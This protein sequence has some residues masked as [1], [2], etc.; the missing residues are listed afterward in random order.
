VHAIWRAEF[1]N[2]TST[3]LIAPVV[4]ITPVPLLY[5]VRTFYISCYISSTTHPPQPTNTCNEHQKRKRKTYK[6][7]GKKTKQKQT[8]KQTMKQKHTI[9][10][11]SLVQ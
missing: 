9:Y 7:G 5:H 3:P 6:E 8:N 11:I 4:T 1:E 2:P 10:I